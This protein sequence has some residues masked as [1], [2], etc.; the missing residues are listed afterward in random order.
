MDMNLWMHGSTRW[1]P[2][3]CDEVN[4]FIKNPVE[5]HVMTNNEIEIHCPCS[6][7]KNN[8]TWKD[9]STISS[10]KDNTV[11][12]HHDEAVFD[13][14]AGGRISYMDACVAD[15][16]AEM[17]GYKQGGGTGDGERVGDCG[18]GGGNDSGHVSD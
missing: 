10:M 4:V 15:L 8:L 3:F 9:A 5:T 13:A 11:W 1:K 17:V 7:C 18:G 2:L 16:N 6:Y 14:R 12:I